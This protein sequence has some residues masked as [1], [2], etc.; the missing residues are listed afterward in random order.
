MPVISQLK[1][2]KV[3][4]V[5]ILGL[6]YFAKLNQNG[7]QP[8]PRPTNKQRDIVPLKYFFKDD[9]LLETTLNAVHCIGEVNLILFFYMQQFSKQFFLSRLL[10]KSNLLL[11]FLIK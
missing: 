2:I 10:N 7:T 1:K 3:S 8:F 5:L 11:Y 9:S 6:V 4:C